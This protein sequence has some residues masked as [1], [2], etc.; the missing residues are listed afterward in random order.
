MIPAALGFRVHSGWAALVAV[1]G[2]FPATKILDRRRIEIADPH[3]AGSKQPY[4]AAERLNLVD[5][6]NLIGRCAE[7]S[8]RLAEQCITGALQDLASRGFDVIT[9]AI[10]DASGRPLPALAATLAS[11]AL[12]HTAEGEFFRNVIASVCSQHSLA[13]TRIKEKELLGRA[14]TAFALGPEMLQ[15]V[16]SGLGRSLGPPWTQ[17]Q[18]FA[19]LLAC[20]ALPPRTAI[21]SAG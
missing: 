17:D 10:S 12:I 6:E 4:H 13:V 2:S 18:K 8:I 21:H 3:F 14:S 15:S 20:L 9:C 16:L 1:A 5:A 19:T 11:H 7:S